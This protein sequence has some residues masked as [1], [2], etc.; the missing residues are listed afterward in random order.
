MD[1]YISNLP[2]H[3]GTTELKKVIRYGLFPYNLRDFFQRIVKRKNKTAYSEF[4]IV[5]KKLGDQ[6]I[7]YAHAVIQPDTVARRV[8]RHLNQLT[9]RGRSLRAREYANRDH[10]NERRR[11]QHKN[12]YAV[13][14]YNRRVTE[15]RRFSAR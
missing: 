5:V 2:E 9:F 3:L 7:C 4:E 8:L 6:S 13:T 12:L 1:I 14:A 15:R 11:N 10:R